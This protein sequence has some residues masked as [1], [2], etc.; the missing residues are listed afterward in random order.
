MDERQEDSFHEDALSNARRQHRDAQIMLENGRYDSA[1]THAIVAL[2]ELGKS[3][4]AKWNVKNEGSKRANPNHIEKQSAAF[5]ILAAHQISTH[6]P[7]RRNVERINENGEPKDFITLGGYCEQFAHARAGFYENLRMSLTYADKDP[8]FS[9]QSLAPNVTVGIAE[10]II[11][12]F[13]DAL[14]AMS[15]DHAHQIAASI[16]KNNLGRW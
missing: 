10:E 1:T 15:N 6:I 13:D 2:E 11:S 12:Y 16:Y 5:A 8:A 14:I 9:R 4:V 7:T 3:L